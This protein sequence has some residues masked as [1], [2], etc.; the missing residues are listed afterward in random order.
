MSQKI[1]TV[2]F[3]DDVL[4]TI[5]QDN[6]Q[7]VAI[8]PIVENMGLEWSTQ[9]QK[10]D[11]NPK[12]NC[13]HM[14]TVAKDGKI[15]EVLCMPIK[16]L[17]GWLFSINPEKV[18]ADI[19]H[20]VEQYQEECFTVLHDYWHKGVAVNP[21]SNKTDR[22]DLRNA[23]ST[24]I[25]KTNLGFDEA[26]K[27]VYQYMGVESIDEITTVDLP[28]ATAYVHSLIIQCNEPRYHYADN[29]RLVSKV[30][31]DGRLWTRPLADNEHIVRM[32]EIPQLLM[33]ATDITHDELVAINY[34]SSARL[35]SMLKNPPFLTTL[36]DA[37]EM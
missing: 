2:K 33:T 23:V 8:R 10:L 18:R 17:N 22:T 19:R 21:R 37:K 15:R 35:A 31:D 4:I 1:A 29:D 5:E 27:M 24:L 14:N 32:D 26:Y 30:D 7:Y 9:K 25:G 28:L 11:R 34:I 13:V 3:Y 12:F 20:I 6:I 16:K 36:D